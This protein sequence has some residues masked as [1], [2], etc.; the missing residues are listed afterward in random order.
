MS[1]SS[2]LQNLDFLGLVQLELA[3]GTGAAVGPHEADG[4]ADSWAA[5]GGAAA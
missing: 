4:G 5:A 1:A 2:V 3:K